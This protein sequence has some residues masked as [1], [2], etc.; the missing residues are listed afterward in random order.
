MSDQPDRTSL[1][2]G[3]QYINLETYRRNGQAVRTPVWFTIHDSKILIVTRDI[4]GK[5]KRIRNNSQV[6]IVPS[7]LRGQ[8]KGEW[9]NGKAAFA[10]AV[11]LEHALKQRSEKYGFK[12]R[13]SGLFS[14]TKGKLIGIVVAFDTSENER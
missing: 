3:H 2:F 5:V 11:E 6:R 10:N 13:L 12:A 14:R 9:V 7:G 4:T 8:P 1:F